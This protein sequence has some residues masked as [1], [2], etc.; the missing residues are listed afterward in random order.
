MTQMESGSSAFR[1][2]VRSVGITEW[3]RILW[4]ISI[5]SLILMTILCLCRNYTPYQIP[6][7]AELT[8]HKLGSLQLHKCIL[9]VLGG[10]KSKIKISIEVIPSGGSERE[11]ISYLSF[12]P[13]L[14]LSV[15]HAGSYFH[16]QGLN[17]C[18]MHWECRVLTYWTTRKVPPCLFLSFW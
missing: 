15:C 14:G 3:T 7:V 13:P 1:Y 18:H 11:S 4:C 9:S 8:C 2:V 10:H 12:F 6:T 16:D 5:N 17:P